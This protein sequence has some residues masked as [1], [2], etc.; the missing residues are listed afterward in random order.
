M[1]GIPF[2]GPIVKSG[3][4]VPYLMNAHDLTG[5]TMTEVPT[6]QC[7]GANVT[8]FLSAIPVVGTLLLKLN[9]VQLS[10]TSDYTL[11]GSTIT[12]VSAP[13]S[14]DSLS[15]TYVAS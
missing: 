9:G 6:G 15:S 4:G 14:G 2:S 5:L 7:N 13:I 11:S 1:A 12:M 10:L 3:S 8:F